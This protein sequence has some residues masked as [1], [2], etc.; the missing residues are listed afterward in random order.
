MRRMSWIAL[1]LVMTASCAKVSDDN[2][3]CQSTEC[4]VHCRSTG[5]DGGHCEGNRCV[6]TDPTDPDGDADGDRDGDL[7]EDLCVPDCEGRECGL[8]PVCGVS[9]GDCPV[10]SSCDEETGTCCAPDCEGRECGP[11]GC[12]G[13]CEPGCAPGAVCDEETGACCT[14][15]CEGRECGP[16]GCGGTCEPGCGDDGVCD[17]EAGTCCEP[18]CE[19]RICG[20]D[21]CGG[22]CRPGCPLG[23]ACDEET[24]TCGQ[25]DLVAGTGCADDER[26]GLFT[27]DDGDNWE[28]ACLPLDPD[29]AAPGED[30]TFTT[31]DP[32]FVAYGNCQSGSWCV[33]SAPGRGRCHRLCTREDASTCAGV[34]PDADGT[35]RDGVCNLTILRDPPVEGLLACLPPSDCDPR[36]Q[37]CADVDDM[38][39]PASDRDGNFATICIPM[40]RDGD[41]PGEGVAGDTCG[42]DTI[43]AYSN[44]CQPGHVCMG[45]N[46]CHPF[47][48]ATGEPPAGCEFVSCSGTLPT[49]IG[50]SDDGWTAMGLGVCY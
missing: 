50:V 27:R 14:P 1:A 13:T 28:V 45:D 6:C 39:L 33:P 20:P 25:C 43:P 30:C 10:G 49:C 21:G 23:E 2:G 3:E 18:A 35:P 7:D 36:C 32:F 24:G 37:D 8:D 4:D 42:T 9:C 26:C 38:C 31:D 16:D 40:S 15:D 22:T 12:G 34:Y 17:E 44:S 19:G 41:L 47:C 48:N 5:R 11:D 46:L 29:A